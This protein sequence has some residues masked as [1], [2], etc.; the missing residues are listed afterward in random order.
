V[1]ATMTIVVAACRSRAQ[2]EPT[3]DPWAQTVVADAGRRGASDSGLPVVAT[4]GE[5]LPGSIRAFGVLMPVGTTEVVA[6]E[7]QKMFYV[8]APMSAVMRYLQARID[9]VS[10]EIHPLGAMIHS[11]SVHTNGPGENFVVDVGVRDEGNRTL[12]TLW[13]HSQQALPAR[14]TEDGLRA[15]GIDPRTGRPTGSNNF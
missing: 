13:N 2:T 7:S 12:V 8:Q 5:L 9:I 14:T 15:A 11:A 3:E 10:G 4:P 1:L 6:G